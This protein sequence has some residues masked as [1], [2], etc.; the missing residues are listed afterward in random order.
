MLQD[1]LL[2][3]VKQDRISLPKKLLPQIALVKH[4]R[5]SAKI[6]LLVCLIQASDSQV[7]VKMYVVSLDKHD[8]QL[9]ESPL[10][11]NNVLVNW[12]NRH[13]RTYQPELKVD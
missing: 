10:V 2:L 9:R 8:R 1:E 13:F 12:D 5:I 6:L 11:Q 7:A 4:V 3:G